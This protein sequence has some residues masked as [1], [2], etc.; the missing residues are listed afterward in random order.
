MEVLFFG[1]SNTKIF[2]DLGTNILDRHSGLFVRESMFEFL[3]DVALEDEYDL[4]ICCIGHN[5][6]GAVLQKRNCWGITE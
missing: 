5:D 3:L 1:D 4:I 6:W 2:V